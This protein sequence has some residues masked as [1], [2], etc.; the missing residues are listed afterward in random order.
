MEC[1]TNL[2]AG[3]KEEAGR[4]ILGTY[5]FAIDLYGAIYLF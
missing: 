1:F 2:A 5:D 4:A 3:K